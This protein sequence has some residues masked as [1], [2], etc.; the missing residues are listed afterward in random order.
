MA[1][2]LKGQTKKSVGPQKRYRDDLEED[3]IYV[4]GAPFIKF[5]DS[6]NGSKPGDDLL[7]ESCT[8][9]IRRL[10]PS[11][12][13]KKPPESTQIWEGHVD[14]VGVA[15]DRPELLRTLYPEH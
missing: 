1:R 5:W 7:G 14:A 6:L 3:R 11:D 9:A 2:L 4:D 10:Y 12:H 8:R 13:G 15:L